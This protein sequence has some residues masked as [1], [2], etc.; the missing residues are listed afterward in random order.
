MLFVVCTIMQMVAAIGVVELDDALDTLVFSDTQSAAAHHLHG[1]Q[2][3]SLNFTMVR[4][5]V[6]A[7][8]AS[9]LLLPQQ[10]P[11]IS[12]KL[13]DHKEIVAIVR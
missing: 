12:A 11:K 13:Q 7:Y 3:R 10:Q 6:P 1:E 8:G 9:I 5:M 4:S 2:G